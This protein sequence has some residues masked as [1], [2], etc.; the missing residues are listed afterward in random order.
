VRL[1]KETHGLEFV[2]L[3]ISVL[4][5]EF[6]MKDG[7]DCSNRRI[8]NEECVTSLVW[9]R[10]VEESFEKVHPR[11]VFKSKPRGSL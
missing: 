6:L 10:I 1:T 7:Q 11:R 5:F 2:S 8:F 4:I 3:V 9:R